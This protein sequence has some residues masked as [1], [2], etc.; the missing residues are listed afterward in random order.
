LPSLRLM[1]CPSADPADPAMREP[2][3]FAISKDGTSYLPAAVPVSGDF[4]AKLQGAASP[5]AP[6]QIFRFAA[7]CKTTACDKWTG[8]RCGLIDQWV[9]K[10]DPVAGALPRCA[11]RRTCRAFA[12]AGVE[13]CRRCPIV[14]TK[15]AVA[16]SP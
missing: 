8:T 12:Q 1:L 16:A 14:V 6:D 7:E 3:I 2:V 13:A 15:A 10:L 11:I 5:L 9:A 4:N